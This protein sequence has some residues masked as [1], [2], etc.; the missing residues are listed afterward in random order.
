M[1]KGGRVYAD[2]GGSRQI[3]PRQIGPRQIG[4]R[5]IGPRQ[6]GPWQ[7]GPRKILGTANW[8]P[9]NLMV[10]NWANWPPNTFTFSIFTFKIPL[11]QSLTFPFTFLAGAL[12]LSVRVLI[13]PFHSHHCT[14]FEGP[15]FPF[16]FLTSAGSL[17][18]SVRVGRGP[19]WCRSCHSLTHTHLPQTGNSQTYSH[20]PTY[21][22]LISPCFQILNPLLL[23]YVEFWHT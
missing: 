3:G 19:A 14:Y 23:L 11:F 15:L 16:T 8:A 20:Q 21:L 2:E 18:L 9:E 12:P 5:Q 10:A 13:D 4:P 7:I 1:G 17:P 22:K 6:I